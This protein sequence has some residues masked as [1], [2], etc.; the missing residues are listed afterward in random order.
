MWKTIEDHP[1]YA[2]SSEGEVMNKK[3]GAIKTLRLKYGY[4]HLGVMMP[5]RKKKWLSVH[6]LVAK[7]FIPTVDYTLVVNHKDGNRANNHYSN[8]EWCTQLENIRHAIRTGAHKPTLINNRPVYQYDLS[9]NFIREWQSGRFA[10]RELGMDETLISKTALGLN[11]RKQTGG[12]RW[13]FK[14]RVVP[15]LY[16]SDCTYP[17]QYFSV[18]HPEVQQ[19]TTLALL[20]DDNCSQ[21]NTNIS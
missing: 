20:S 2:I 6:R 1:M 9:G 4:T 3:S 13:A 8:L 18:S 21:H 17:H 5:D 12:F 15:V 10:A 11:N 7:A 16:Q 14:D 19:T